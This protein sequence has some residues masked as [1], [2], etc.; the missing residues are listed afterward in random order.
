MDAALKP[1]D[2]QR[3][4]FEQDTARGL[5]W[6]VLSSRKAAPEEKRRTQAY[7]KFLVIV[8]ILHKVLMRFESHI[9]ILNQNPIST[10]TGW[11]GC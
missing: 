5:S 9:H 3:W 7:K 4:P 6:S 8:A 1:H 11:T 10:R 2:G